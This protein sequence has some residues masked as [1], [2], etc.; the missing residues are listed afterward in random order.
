MISS[1]ERKD[2]LHALELR[3]R[4]IQLAL[5]LV[6]LVPE[7]RRPDDE[8]WR[9]LGPRFTGLMAFKSDDPDAAG[10]DGDNAVPPAC[11]TPLDL[12]STC[13]L[14]FVLSHG[15]VLISKSVP[16]THASTTHPCRRASPGA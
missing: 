4:E 12:S 5:G 13:I 16:P 9:Y 10:Q 8:Q 2:G 15:L 14:T 6:Q 3:G 11:S 7:L 1:R